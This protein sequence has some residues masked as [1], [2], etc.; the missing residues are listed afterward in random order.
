MK[1]YERLR[2]GNY[3]TLKASSFQDLPL[4]LIRARIARGLTQKEL[5]KRLGVMEQQIQR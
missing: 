3:R 5:G 4:E 1:E 2:S